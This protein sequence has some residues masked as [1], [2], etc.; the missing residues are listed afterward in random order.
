M[1]MTREERVTKDYIQTNTL[2][3]RGYP[4]YASILGNFDLNLTNNPTVIGYM[5]PAKGRIVLNRGLDEDQVSVIIRHEILHFFLEH[6]L[7][8]LKKLAAEHGLDYDKI[9][10]NSLNDLKRKLYSNDLFN[11]AADY[12][13]S[14][15]GY[16]EQDKE[17]VRNILLNGQVLS[18]LVTED[19]HPDWVDLSVEEMYDKLREEMQNQRDQQ[20]D[21]SDQSND[22]D[23]SDGSQSND[24]SSSSSGDN[25]NQSDN[26][27]GN[28]DQSDS[29]YDS[30]ENTSSS[31]SGSSSKSDDENTDD[32]QSNESSTDSDDSNNQNGDS[33]STDNSKLKDSD[34]N[35]QSSQSQKGGHGSDSGEPNKPSGPPQIGDKGDE[36]ITAEED[37]EREAQIQSEIEEYGDEVES[38]LDK[39][40]RLKRISKSFDDSEN[41]KAVRDEASD[42]I[43]K[44]RAARA[45]RDAAKYNSSP[46]KKFRDNLNRF[47][48]NEVGREKTRTWKKE[49]P[50]YEG[51]GIMRR[52]S[53]RTYNGRIP[54]I[55][56]YFDRSGSWDASK[57]KV[58]MDAIGTLNNY[59]RQGQI[60]IKLYYFN[61]QI[62][63]EDPGGRGGTRGTPIIEHI[64]QTKPDN[65]IIMTDSDI[66]D[67]DES[68]T[69]PGAVWL[70]FKGGQSKNLIDHIHGRKQT[71]IYNLD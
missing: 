41:A 25:S 64:K 31:Q 38:D 23:D 49:D 24:Q 33:S 59:V 18:G 11:R 35:S 6:E 55:N 43:N 65:V 39:E 14:N 7:R 2:A 10:D 29:S 32:K 53:A 1:S 27:K 9:D 46:I 50:R 42:K 36:S 5:E 70:L 12:E 21:S 15:R 20:S 44:E 4:T 69:V 67:I 8:L 57:T 30:S 52:G 61:T 45:A 22:Q 47:I 60:K 54:L 37:A 48:K 71:N 66:T 13:I 40:E 68:V 17:D 62:H 3:K 28:S 26:S 51:T 56:V 16:T 63:S 34:S 58:G 19:D